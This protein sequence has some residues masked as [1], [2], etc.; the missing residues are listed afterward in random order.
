MHPSTGGK[1]KRVGDALAASWGDLR[2]SLGEAE[3]RR[4][5]RAELGLLPRL[6]LRTGPWRLREVLGRVG[7]LSDVMRLNASRDPEGLAFEMG[8]TRRTWADVAETSARLAA[9]LDARGVRAGDVIALLGGNSPAYLE[10]V[11]GVC[12]L[13]ATTALINSHLDG[14]PLSHAVRASGAKVAIAEAGLARRLQALGGLGLEPIFVYGGAGG[15]DSLEALL[16]D[17]SPEEAPCPELDPS[18]DFVYIYTSGTTGLPKPCRVSHARALLVGSTFGPLFFGF[19]PGDKL[20][21]VLPLYHSSALLIGAG[22]C[23]MTKT[24]MALREGFSASAF[25]PDVQRTGATAMLYVGEL[26]R[27]LLNSPPHEAERGNS[28]RIALGNGLRPDIWQAF[29]SRF[30]IPEIREFY[31]ATEAPGLLVNLTGKIGSIGRLPLRRLGL[32]K[33]V[34]YDVDADAHICDERGALIECEAQEPGELL[35]RLFERKVSAGME[36][37]GY[38]DPEASRSKILE[39]VF[40]PGDRWYRSGDLLRM[41]ELGFLYFVDRIGDTYRW[42]GENVS[43]AEVADALSRAPGVIEATVVGVAIPGREGQC[44]LAALVSEG[45]LDLEAFAAQLRG[46]LAPYAQPRFLRIVEDLQRTGTFKIQKGTLRSEGIDPGHVSDP[47]YV[48]DGE[49]YLPL[50]SERYRR[51][52]SGDLRL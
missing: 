22:S 9:L 17:A 18:S 1:L 52:L 7:G 47:L 16:A 45:P 35:I 30:E 43:T 44:G 3:W 48:L 11:L 4:S 38:T 23:L 32:A 25:W 39:D 31:A 6:A 8:E 20:Y 28:L 33:L 26:C 13:G 46:Q 12:Q 34:R 51:I 15:D 2:R 21:S 10:Y 29:A 5:L 14:A 24:P 40:E 36:F 50:T 37:R 41:D 49:A 42:K 27:Y 19:R